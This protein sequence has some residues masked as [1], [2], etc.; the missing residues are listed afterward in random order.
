MTKLEKLHLFLRFWFSPWGAA[1]GAR[2][3]SFYGDHY[4]GDEQVAEQIVQSILDGTDTDKVDWSA[5][6]SFA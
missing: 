4:F 1:K 5:L 6:E 2:W 3:E